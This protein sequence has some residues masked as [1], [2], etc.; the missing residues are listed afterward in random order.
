MRLSVLNLRYQ[1][2]AHGTTQTNPTPEWEAWNIDGDAITQL[3]EWGAARVDSNWL[4]LA[5]TIDWSLKSKTLDAVKDFIPDSPIPARTLVK[6][7]LNLVELG[8]VRRFVRLSFRPADAFNQNIPL[9]QKRV[10]EFAQE[11]I[12]YISSLVGVVGEERSVKG[13]LNKIW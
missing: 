6:A 1:L 12:Q 5:E 3:R 4:K 13:D 10:Y 2:T 11:A 8:I 7:L 9:I